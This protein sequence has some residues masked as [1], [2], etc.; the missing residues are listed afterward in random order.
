MTSPDQLEAS[1]AHIRG[2]ALLNLRVTRDAF[3]SAVSGLSEQQARFKP[4]PDRWSI[5]E[6]V[7]HVA[8]A[9]HGMYR[10]ISDL[11]E[12]TTDP[13]TAESAA[14]LARTSDRKKLPL[15]APERALPKH[16]FDS[17]AAAL[18]KFLENRARTIEFVENCTDDLRFR[19]IQH[20]LGLINGQDCLTVLIRHA[21]RHIDQIN[22]LRADP[23][24]PR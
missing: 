22:E 13:H 12:V 3:Q 2:L 11:H 15:A 19:V 16:R 20:P 18:A 4:S 1:D 7:E 21:D 23:G 5:E 17:L 9:E 10:Y 8:V 24:F 14:S 6:I